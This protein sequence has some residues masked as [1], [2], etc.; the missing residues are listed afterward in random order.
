[1]NLATSGK[2]WLLAPAAALAFLAALVAAWAAL[3]PATLVPLFD[4]DGASPVELMTLPLFALVVPL[5]WLC[6]PCGGTTRR[7][8][9]WASVWSLLAVMA[10]VRE[11]DVHKALF[12]RIW[13][14][15]AA[16]FHGTV[17]K[18]KFLKA[19]G[20]PL[21]PKLFVAV[22]FAL[23]FAAVL[24]PLVRYIVPL[25]KGFFRLQPVAWTMAVFGGVS[26]MVLVVDRLPAML[27][28]AGAALSES[29]LAL[30][31]AFE[32]GGEMLMALLALLAVLQAHLTFARGEG[33]S[34]ERID[35]E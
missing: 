20:V 12:A 19:A 22:F 6:P 9:A 15:V 30:L 5:V 17:Y 7:Q 2:S 29:S 3:E 1:M 23:F 11:T 21:M 10:L 35:R 28:H 8:C 14:E 18:M 4:N 27:R 25:V 32:E 26:V 24:I 34:K 33:V 31:T 13:P 16:N